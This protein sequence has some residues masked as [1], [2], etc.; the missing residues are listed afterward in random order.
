MEQRTRPRRRA[1]RSASAC[2]SRRAHP[3]VVQGVDRVASK[4]KKKKKTRLA[5]TRPLRR[6]S[7]LER[8]DRVV[9]Q[10]ADARRACG[11]AKRAFVVDDCARSASLRRGDPA[12][13]PRASRRHRLSAAAAAEAAAASRCRVSTERGGSALPSAGSTHQAETQRLWAMNRVAFEII[14]ASAYKVFTLSHD[15]SQPVGSNSPLCLSNERKCC[16]YS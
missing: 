14:A 5:S 1:E 16:G 8:R 3:C 7:R 9:L 11:R 12:R 6:S 13:D 15:W 4:K 10:A 2:P